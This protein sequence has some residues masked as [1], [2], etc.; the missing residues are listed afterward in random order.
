[1]LIKHRAMD[2]SKKG[3]GREKQIGGFCL[4]VETPSSVIIRAPGTSSVT[5]RGGMWY[6][7]CSI[8]QLVIGN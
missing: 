7:N 2:L 6:G 8:Y 5:G 3:M 4:P 1:M